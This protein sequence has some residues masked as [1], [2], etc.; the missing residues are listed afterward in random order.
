MHYIFMY[1]ELRLLCQCSRPHAW[2]LPK[3]WLLSCRRQE[4]LVEINT[5]SKRFTFVPW[6]RHGT[7]LPCFRKCKDPTFSVASCIGSVFISHNQHSRSRTKQICIVLHSQVTIYLF[8]SN[9]NFFIKIFYF[10]SCWCWLFVSD[11]GILG[12]G[13]STV[14]MS[15]FIGKWY[16]YAMDRISQKSGNLLILMNI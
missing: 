11:I 16:I 13:G 4:L 15:R 8:I 10:C 12:K 9:Q 3:Q 14:S 7:K 5:N 6:Q 2:I 1:I